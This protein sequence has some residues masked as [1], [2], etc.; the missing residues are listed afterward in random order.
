MNKPIYRFNDMIDYFERKG[1]TYD[2]PKNEVESFLSKNNYFY[3]LISY[4]KNFEQ[5]KSFAFLLDESI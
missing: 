5:I 4:R 1:I 3:K 2:T